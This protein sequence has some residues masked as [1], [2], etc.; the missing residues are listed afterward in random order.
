MEKGANTIGRLETVMGRGG[1]DQ[2]T[3]AGETLSEKLLM[4]TPFNLSE[5]NMENAPFDVFVVYLRA[6]QWLQKF[7]KFT[8]I[9]SIIPEYKSIKRLPLVTLL[10]QAVVIEMFNS[11]IS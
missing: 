3:G 2:T 4:T 11:S 10:T 5:D 7:L 6:E 1:T 9:P 8:H